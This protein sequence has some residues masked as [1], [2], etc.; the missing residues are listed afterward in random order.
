MVFNR[1]SVSLK[2]QWDMTNHLQNKKK[3]K[4]KQI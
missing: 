3:W 4:V 1:M 2:Q